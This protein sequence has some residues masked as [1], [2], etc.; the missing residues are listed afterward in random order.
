[1]STKTK[2][3]LFPAPPESL[4]PIPFP[5]A[6]PERLNGN[7]SAVAADAAIGTGAPRPTVAP[8][9]APRAPAQPRAFWR[10]ATREV[11]E[12]LALTLVVF[13]L[14]R[15]VI[16]NFRIEGQSME[17]NFH[18]GQFLIVNKFAY[19]FEKP[20]RGDVVV[21]R[22]PPNPARDFIKRIIALPGDRV[23]VAHGRVMVNSQWLDEPYPLNTGTYSFPE[24]VVGESELFVLG[25][26]RNNSSDSHSWGMLPY[27]NLIGKAWVSYWPPELFGIVQQYPVSAVR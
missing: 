11:V 17:P 7:Q 9:S 16:Q 25:D 14:I 15:V 13:F 8:I 3:S 20:Q 24:A 10:R 26:N 27:E 6:P 19:Q 21:F 18:D 5:S 4:K 2:P 12:T 23:M 1:M 22:Y